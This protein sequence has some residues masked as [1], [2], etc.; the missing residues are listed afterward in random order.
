MGTQTQAHND[1]DIANC[2]GLLP[3]VPIMAQPFMFGRAPEVVAWYNPGRTT[4][5]KESITDFGLYQSNI[6][7]SIGK[8]IGYAKLKTPMQILKDPQLFTADRKGTGDFAETYNA[9]M[10]TRSFPS[11][12]TKASLSSLGIL[13][14]MHLVI[15]GTNNGKVFTCG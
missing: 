5:A 13:E 7:C 8:G 1:D 10:I 14:N 12:K 3:S 9:K 15:I 2:N 11:L 6:I 4:K